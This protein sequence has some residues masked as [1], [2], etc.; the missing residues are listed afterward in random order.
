MIL[1]TER[2]V[3][4]P[5]YLS[6]LKTTHK[7][8]SDIENTQYM[9][10]LPNLTEYET[11]SFLRNAEKEWQSNSPNFYEFAITLNNIH[12]GGVSLYLNESKTHGE[13][14]WILDK[15]YWNNGYAT[16]AA[17]AIIKFAKNQLH[18]HKI[19][20]QCDYRNNASE[21]IMKKLGMTLYDNNG[22]RIYVKRKETAKELTYILHLNNLQDPI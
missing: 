22:I 12:I 11:E 17:R 3:L 16:E 8:T 2:L 7:Y 13:I 18:L 10:R 1:K 14:G 9:I 20:A 5:L 21:N 4:R 6:D 19:T 15:Q